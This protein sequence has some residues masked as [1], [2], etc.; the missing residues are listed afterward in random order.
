[1]KK[2][3]RSSKSARRKASRRIDSGCSVRR[4]TGLCQVDSS[5]KSN[6]SRTFRHMASRKVVLPAALIFPSNSVIE[7]EAIQ[8]L[9]THWTTSDIA[10]AISVAVLNFS[11]AVG[12]WT[13]G[14]HSGV[15]RAKRI[16]S[17][18]SLLTS[19]SNQSRISPLSGKPGSSNSRRLFALPLSPAAICWACCCPLGSWSGSMTMWRSQRGVQSF[20]KCDFRAPIGKL[21]AHIP[22]SMSW[23]ACFSPSVIKI[24][25][26]R[27]AAINLSR[28]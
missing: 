21:V 15:W 24:G 10:L 12:S 11:S 1:M 2:S 20:T 3:S 18:I 27:S 17:S 25:F 9:L 16:S 8:G 5:M 6:P 4:T 26:V 7:P 22:R 19:W 23:S 13:C 14:S 28:W